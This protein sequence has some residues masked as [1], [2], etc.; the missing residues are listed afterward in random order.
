MAD[1]LKMCEH[2]SRQTVH[3]QDMRAAVSF[4]QRWGDSETAIL[5]SQEIRLKHENILGF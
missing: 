1:A 5:R 4:R 2:R 3:M